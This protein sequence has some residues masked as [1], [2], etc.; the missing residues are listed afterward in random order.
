[1]WAD[2]LVRYRLLHAAL[3]TPSGQWLVQQYP[4]GP[5]EVLSGPS[6]VLD[7]AARLQHQTRTGRIRTR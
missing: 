6:A 3:P 2:V 5:V 4:Y 7:L 1:M